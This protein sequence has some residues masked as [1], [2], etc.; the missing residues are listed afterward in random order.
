MNRIPDKS[1]K[2]VLHTPRE[3]WALECTVRLIMMGYYRVLKCTVCTVCGLSGK[4]GKFI[5]NKNDND[6]FFFS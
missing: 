3:A 1:G 4:S 6:Y 2:G 5:D